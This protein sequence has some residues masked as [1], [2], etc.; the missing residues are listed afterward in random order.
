MEGRTLPRQVGE[1]GQGVQEHLAQEPVGQV[2]AV[3]RPH[4]FDRRPVDPLAADP[5]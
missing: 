4:A 5:G 1:D 3:T 2:P